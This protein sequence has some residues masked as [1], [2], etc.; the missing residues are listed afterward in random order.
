MITV[1]IQGNSKYVYKTY[2]SHGWLL[3]VRIVKERETFFK[4]EI[5]Y[6]TLARNTGQFIPL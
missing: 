6:M 3:Y 4:Y 5:C 1:P 2:L